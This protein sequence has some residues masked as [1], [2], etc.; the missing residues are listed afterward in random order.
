MAMKRLL[1][2]VA[3]AGVLA[4]PFLLRPRVAAR[5]QAEE[6]VVIITSHNEA[7]RSELGPA[8]RDWYRRRTGRSIA[9]DWR[10]I[11]GTSEINRYLEAEYVAAF[12]QY[13][14][15]RLGRRW[16]DEVQSAFRDPA[17]RPGADPAADSPAQAAR[18]AF[19][20]SEVGCGIDL[21][22]G[23]GSYDYVWHA[24]AGRLVD[25]GIQRL[26]P[27][28]FGEAVIP[29]SHTGEAYWDPQGLWVGAVL[30][31]Y[32]I[33][34]NRDALRRLG[35]GHEPQ[36]W[37]DLEDPRYRGEIALCDPTRSSSS[38]KAFE[39]VI[40]Q[41]M[42]R[43]W[44]ALVA[45]TGRP[46]GE[47]EARAVRE[48]WRAGL[49]LLQRIG[50]NARYFTDNSQKPPMD[51]MQGDSAAG[52]GIDFYGRAQEETAARRSGRHRLGFV[53][54][55]DGT[56]L[57]PD[58]IAQLRGAPHPQAALAFIEFTLSSEGQALW[59]L[60]VG[61]PGGPRVYALRR[62]PIRR[63]LYTEEH[64]QALRSDP[65]ASPY[66]AGQT[67]VYHP[68]WTNGL[69][70]ELALVVRVMCQDTHPELVRAWSAIL[71]AGMPPEALRVMQDV[72]VV[73][74]DQLN[75]RIR[76]VLDSRNQVE[77]VR[78]AR[79]LAGHFREQYRRAE[80][81]AGAGK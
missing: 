63:D 70:R 42:N 50:A 26:H 30:S 62:L 41:Q 52:L 59:D 77:E 46:A 2:L 68:A 21:F 24:R 45:G 25:S 79:E 57:S 39:N 54:P 20:D 6:S 73:D 5:E 27:E 14:T 66:A 38:A 4:L 71:A 18:R 72:S 1:L 76:S 23:G 43:R 55:A 28:W 34:F 60:R 16:S 40:Q 80:E 3:L 8:F 67:F 36:D 81:L 44:A 7:I 22:H 13:W 19:L 51:V 15:G 17:V 9:V 69:M 32:G 48:G 10:V 64:F 37:A 65:E 75:G 35:L 12:R 53:S 74:Y 49:Q 56:V 29:A 78:L 58:P 33:L 11:G 47:L 61:T 31:S